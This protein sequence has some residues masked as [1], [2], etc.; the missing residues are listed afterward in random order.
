MRNDQRYTRL[1]LQYQHQFEIA[2]NGFLGRAIY[3]TYVN[4]DGSLNFYD[5]ANIGKLY[6]EA[7][8]NRGRGNISQDKIFDSNDLIEN[9]KQA[10]KR[11]EADK[12]IV[13]TTAI[14]RYYKTQNENDY[15]YNPSKHTF[16]WRL[17]DYY[18]ITN[19]TKPFA[20]TGPIAEGYVG[21]VADENEN[22]TSADIENSLRVLYEN[23]IQKDS[24]GAAIKGDILFGRDNSIQFAVKKG[25]F[26][27]AMV[28]QY[29]RLAINIQRMKQISVENFEKLLP[30]LIKLTK[31]TDQVID[32]ANKKASEQMKENIR[33]KF[34]ITIV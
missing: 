32:V 22:V 4:E 28:G 31:L 18:H 7:T 3:L 30:S 23:Y 13:Y 19:Y 12:K 20:N 16:Y 17:N 9:I 29:M 5:D 33:N 6:Q 10:L 1:M 11:S 25:S 14:E 8:A 15:K 2:L 27:T 26:S 24:I 21:A 34:N